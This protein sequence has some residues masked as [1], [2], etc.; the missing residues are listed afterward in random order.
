M[1]FCLFDFVLFCF[2]CL[3]FIIIIIIIIIIF[4]NSISSS[5][6]ELPIGSEI[7]NCTFK[8]TNKVSIIIIIIIMCLTCIFNSY[9]SFLTIVEEVDEEDE[10]RPEMPLE[11]ESI[12]EYEGKKR[13][14]ITKQPVI[15]F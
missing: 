10:G 3:L 8:N 6:C 1:N 2:C 14:Y 4:N 12:P 13:R 9:I 15:D 11:R 5:I 7:Y